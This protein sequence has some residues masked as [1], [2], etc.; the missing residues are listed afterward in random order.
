M[1]GLMAIPVLTVADVSQTLVRP[2]VWLKAHYGPDLV[3]MLIFLLSGMALNTA[4][5]R[6]GI[7]DVKGTMLA[8]FLIFIIAPLIASCMSLLPLQRGL[9]IGLLLVSAMPT[10]LSSGVVMTGSSGGNMAHALFITIV[11]NALAVATIPFTLT[12]LFQSTGGTGV[13]EI[14]Q[15][16]IMVKLATRV[17]LPLFL[18][19]VLRN[20]FTAAIRPLLPFTTRGNQ[21][22]I[23]I[24]VWMAVCAGRD[25]IISGFNAIIAVIIVVFC[26]HLLLVSAAI[27]LATVFKIAKTKRESIVFMGGQKTLPLSVILQ[28][29][30]F[31]EFGIA[32]VVCVMHH[33]IHLIMDAALINYLKNK[34]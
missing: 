34:K 32:L 2:G 9:I 23:L 8:L 28:V 22:C 4:Q 7:A 33:I 6:D 3:I 30:L 21:I 20:F 5:V 13:I 15:L 27:A 29:S 19:I 16:G 11:A 14:D 17:L 1:L 18:G 25:A 31:P 10:T 26:F 12:I 24:M